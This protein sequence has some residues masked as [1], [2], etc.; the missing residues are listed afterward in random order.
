MTKH[1]GHTLPELLVGLAVGLL[2]VAAATAAFN[3]SQQTWV[4]MAAADSVH[5]NARVALRQLR[6][7]AYLAGGADLL[8][9]SSN[10]VTISANEEQGQ[11]SVSGFNG[12]KEIESISLAHMRTLDAMDCQGNTGSTQSTVRSDFKL[13]TNKEL[14]CKDVNVNGST[15]QALA[16]GVEDFQV[17]YA[18]AMPTTQTIQW[19][20]AD[21]VAQM[22]HVVGIEV[23]L[24]VASIRTVHHTKASTSQI[25]CQG[26][27]LPRDGRLRRVFR[28]VI[29]LRNRVGVMP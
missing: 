16:E 9:A 15:Y 21:Q 2:V 1:V 5:A 29:A 8:L 26:E 4:A 11:A 27:A 24:R 18:Q 13:N 19:L 6:E 17:L 3:T 28:Q 7:Q 14:S 22:S 23:C 12:N 10:R 25:G 20:T